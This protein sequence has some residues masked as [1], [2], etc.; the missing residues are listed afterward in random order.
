MQ[1]LD[2]ALNYYQIM[3]LQPDFEIDEASLK[4]QYLLLQQT[5]HP[6]FHSGKSKVLLD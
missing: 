2:P 5:V 6:D 1:P 4:K 3:N